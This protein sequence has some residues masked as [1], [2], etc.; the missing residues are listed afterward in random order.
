MES[1]RTLN[2]FAVVDSDSGAAWDIKPVAAR[3]HKILGSE[4]IRRE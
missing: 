1:D 4:R 2:L 3:A